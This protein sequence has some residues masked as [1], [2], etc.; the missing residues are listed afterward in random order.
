ML[1]EYVPAYVRDGLAQGLAGTKLQEGHEAL[2]A[3]QLPQAAARLK[4]ALEMSP[5][6]ADAHLNLA[7]AMRRALR[8]AH[9]P[10]PG[11][12]QR[13]RLES[14]RH[15]ALAGV[16]TRGDPTR[17]FQVHGPIDDDARYALGRAEQFRGR[18]GEAKDILSK[19]PQD[20]EDAREALKEISE[21]EKAPAPRPAGS[22]S[23]FR[24]SLPRDTCARGLPPGRR[25]H[26]RAQACPS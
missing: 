20:H 4:E 7:I 13:R 25:P 6:D 12:A 3:G 5:S 19:L 8:G 24:M 23:A 1:L 17:Q 16:L 2:S 14:E 21:E 10:D 18:L 26:A 22:G 9:A 15:I 11:T